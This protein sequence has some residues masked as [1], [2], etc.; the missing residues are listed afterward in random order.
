MGKIAQGRGSELLADAAGSSWEVAEL[1]RSLVFY[2]GQ[3]WELLRRAP[4]QDGGSGRN[5][6]G[7]LC[8]QGDAGRSFGERHFKMETPG[9]RN[10]FIMALKGRWAA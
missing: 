9:G 10:R 8:S 2:D 1:L 3:P 6:G 7:R 5:C 4:F